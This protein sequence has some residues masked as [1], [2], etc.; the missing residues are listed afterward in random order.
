MIAP[1]FDDEPEFVR[2][3]E[4]AVNGVLRRHSPAA[5]ALVKIDNW[6]GWKWLGFSGTVFIGRYARP[7]AWHIPSDRRPRDPIR[8]PTFVPDRV[9]SQR[10]FVAPDYQETDPGKLLHE[11]IPSRVARDRIAAREEP[12]TAPAWYSG[13]SKTNGRGSLMVY[14][15]IGASHWPWYAELERGDPWRITADARN[16]KPNEFSRLMEEGSASLAGSLIR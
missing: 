2:L 11:D 16:I 3:V 10:R 5:L 14:V 13:N 15:P 9:V 7:G 6:F 12:E 4:L 8:I 1:E